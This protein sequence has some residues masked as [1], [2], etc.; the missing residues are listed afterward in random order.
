[1]LDCD[2]SSDVCS[3][4]LQTVLDYVAKGMRGQPTMQVEIAGHT[5]SVGSVA[6]NLKLSQ[7]RAESVRAYL[8]AQGIEPER[9]TAKGYGKSE[10]LISPEKNAIDAERNRRVVFKVLGK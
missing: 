1:M 7:R 9:L 8:L 3:S 4:D 10:L 5:D 2:W 6:A